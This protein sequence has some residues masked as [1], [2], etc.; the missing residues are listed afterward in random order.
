MSS[1]W[2][3]YIWIIAIGSILALFWLIQVTRQVPDSDKEDGTM[4]H[5]FDGIEE[6]NKPLPAWW[7]YM[8]WFTM[9][10]GIGYY[11]YYGLGNWNGLGNWSSAGQLAED[12]KAHD[13]EFGAIFAQYAGMDLQSLTEDPRAMRMGQQMYENNCALCHGTRAMGGFGFPN[14]TD[15][16]W[17]YGGSPEA[18]LSSV[19][20][21]RRGQMPPWQA[22][23]GE[24]GVQQVTQYVLSLSGEGH[25]AAQASEGR[26]IFMSSCS[27]CHGQDGTGNEFVGA[28]DLTDSIWLYDNATMS[29]EEDIRQSVAAGRSGEMPA[30]MDRLGE[31]KVK[32]ISAYVYSLSN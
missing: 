20:N 14:L 8:F 26:S 10:F 21:G 24:E 7:L 13:D 28:P 9:V 30:W 3:W 1:F 32:L 22:V 2:H 15:D 18:I 16:D 31:A 11:A 25:N 23:L 12:Q 17:L 4:G 5:T 29:L 27:A 6:Y 19:A